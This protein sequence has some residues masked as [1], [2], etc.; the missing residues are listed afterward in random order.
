MRPIYWAFTKSQCDNLKH[1]GTA[2]GSVAQCQYNCQ[3]DLTCDMY[4]YYNNDKCYRGH[5]D[6]CKRLKT[7]T[8]LSGGK[9]D[10]KFMWKSL[11]NQCRGL[12]QDVHAESFQ[13]CKG[14]CAND[15]NCSVWQYNRDD[16]CWRGIPTE[17]SAEEDRNI[18]KGGYRWYINN[19]AS[20]EDED[21]EEIE[22]DSELPEESSAADYHCPQGY[23]S[24][25]FNGHLKGA[26]HVGCGIGGC[27]SRYVHSTPSACAQRCE[28]EAECEAF[29]FAPVGGDPSY[30]DTTV[31][32]IYDAEQSTPNARLAGSN[33][34]YSQIFCKSADRNR[35]AYLSGL[36]TANGRDG[37]TCGH[38]SDFVHVP[39]DLDESGWSQQTHKTSK[40]GPQECAKICE[41]KCGCVGFEYRFDQETHS[42]CHTWLGVEG[43]VVDDSEEKDDWLTCVPAN[44][45][46]QCLTEYKFTIGWESGV[47]AECHNLDCHTV[48]SVDTC[49]AFCNE[50]DACNVFNYC[51]KGADCTS[52][53]GRCCARKCKS[54]DTSDLELTHEWKGW[55]IYTKKTISRRNR[56]ILSLHSESLST[57]P[58]GRRLLLQA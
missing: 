37:Q 23:W 19:G 51:P 6:D 43:D 31:C 56:R 3:W 33:S 22:T 26:N 52:G 41:D 10:Y 44:G 53:H 16:E 46:K 54:T 32:T 58:I 15:D 13:D 8:V 38:L 11:K 7:L 47:A 5:S 25:G 24:L 34:E 48:D 45:E 30:S 55:D 35:N 49:A 2:D 21:L 4:Q 20:E 57:M 36:R 42:N 28:A 40:H 17:C 18:A 12:T 1:D 9:K 14:N 39:R 29:S 27:D 50:K